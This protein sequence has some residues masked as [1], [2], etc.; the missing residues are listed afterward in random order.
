MHDNGPGVPPE[1]RER[2]FARF[3]RLERHTASGAG[4]GLAIV[5][6]VVEI[7]GGSVHLSESLLL[8]GALVSVR[9]PLA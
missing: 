2:V 5:K 9:L 7:H 1:M 4:L 3:F 6:R 8:G